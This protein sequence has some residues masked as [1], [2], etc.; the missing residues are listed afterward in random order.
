MV[1]SFSG[2]L[3]TLVIVS[4]KLS[5]VTDTLIGHQYLVVFSGKCSGTSIVSCVC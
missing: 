2:S 4:N 3:T 1:L 5:V